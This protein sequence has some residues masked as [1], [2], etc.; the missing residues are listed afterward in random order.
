MSEAAAAATGAEIV[1]LQGQTG[2]LSSAL[3]TAEVALAR[4]DEDVLARRAAVDA[5]P[6][7]GA[8]T[9]VAYP[10]ARGFGAAEEARRA[11]RELAGAQERRTAAAAR[12][13]RAQHE[14]DAH[15]L[16][17]ASA[18]ALLSTQSQEVD[19]RR[20]AV[21]ALRRAAAEPLPTVPGLG[22]LTD[23]PGQIEPSALALADIPADYL[24]RY[25][26]TAA[27]CTGLSWTVLA[28]VGSIE[29]SHGRSTAPGSRSGQN[30]A[31]A[32]G[33]M[34]FLAPTWAG[35]GADGNGDGV[36]DVYNPDDAVAGAARYLCANGAGGLAT[37]PDAIWHY[38]HADWY[39]EQVLTLAS[40]YGVAPRPAVPAPATAAEL[41]VHPNLTL[42]EQAKDD[43]LAGRTDP[44]LVSALAGAVTTH[45]LVVSVIRT[46]HAQY[47]RGTTRE[48]NHYHGRGVD[49][50]GVDGAAVS[51][52][53]DAALALALE[54]LTLD[55]SARPDEVGS[56]WQQLRRFSGAFTDGDHTGH[57]H[58][59]WS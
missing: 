51:T 22:G 13:L 5:R 47:V 21:E 55:R 44:R 56:P 28:A 33:P 39:V 20:N 57:L 2:L 19:Q 17:F 10:P 46:G 43:L 38:N 16:A 26:R 45:R 1:R 35:F 30:S 14:L 42:T 52:A 36:A 34:Q 11:Q 41:A 12:R 58:L 25:R 8:T 7:V 48:S 40:A 59:G 27:T 49:I 18:E 3:A 37:L 54:L 9:P 32:M 15:R 23:V 4:A 53:N 24:T 29:T 31:G 6:P 50:V